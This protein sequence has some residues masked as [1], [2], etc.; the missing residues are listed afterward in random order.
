MPVRIVDAT[1]FHGYVLD[2]PECLK[3]SGVLPSAST[4]PR[5]AMDEAR[6]MTPA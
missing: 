1:E 6:E 3:P 5:Q 4:S 2:H